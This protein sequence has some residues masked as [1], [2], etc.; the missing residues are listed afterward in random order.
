MTVAI[1]LELIFLP[2]GGCR[3]SLS[4]KNDFAFSKVMG[5]CEAKRDKMKERSSRNSNSAPPKLPRGI[6]IIYIPPP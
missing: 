4:S 3:R 6:Y 5:R 2:R 1:V